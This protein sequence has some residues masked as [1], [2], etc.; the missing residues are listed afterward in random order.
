MDSELLD[1]VNERAGRGE[2]V[3]VVRILGGDNQVV[4]VY[5]GEMHPPIADKELEAQVLGSVEALNE[6]ARIADLVDVIDE[7]GSRIT[8]AIEIIKPELELLIF[9]GGHVGQAVALIG[10]LTGYRVTV[11]DDREEFAS[12]Q[13]LP[14]PAI[15]L[16]VSDYASASERVNISTNT[17]VVIVTRGHQYDELCLKSVIGSSASYIGMIGSR[18]RVLSVFKKLAGEGVS[19]YALKR[20]HAPIGLSIG[21][22]SPQEIGVAIVAEIINHVNNS[23]HEFKGE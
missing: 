21:A 11:V 20:V 3:A 5:D 16:V 13:R 7:K 14:D 6:K 1:K 12:R 18:K 17:A 4:S 9:G 8:L 15:N 10:A 23:G 19:E 2:P 22:R